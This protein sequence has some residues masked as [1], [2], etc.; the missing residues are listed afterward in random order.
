MK[1]YLA[2]LLGFLSFVQINSC[3]SIGNKKFDVKTRFEFASRHIWR[4]FASSQNHSYEYAI[5]WKSNRWVGQIW[6][7]YD[8]SPVRH[9]TDY[10]ADWVEFDYTLGYQ[11]QIDGNDVTLAYMYK[12]MADDYYSTQDISVKY[13][14]NKNPWKPTLRFA[15]DWDLKTGSYTT[16]NFGR[17]KKDR[18]WTYAFSLKL[19]YFKNF[20]KRFHDSKINIRTNQMVGWTGM[21]MTGWGD[22]VP[23]ISFTRELTDTTS[24]SL[25]CKYSW[26]SNPKTYQYKVDHAFSWGFS[27]NIKF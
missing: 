27:Y 6:G 18:K 24:Y 22:F 25:K 20:G 1:V 21:S 16:L 15:Y 2:L 26:I 14:Y 12:A 5:D 10:E 11:K 23:R 13:R 19:S 17:S 4:G 9:I 3:L 7:W 8:H